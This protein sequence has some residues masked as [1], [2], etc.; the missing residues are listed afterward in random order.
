MSRYEQEQ[1][2][3][4]LPTVAL[5]PL[6]KALVDAL[7]AEQDK[8]FDVAT[9]VH[10]YLNHVDPKT[11]RKERLN[12]MKA[13][14]RKGGS[15]SSVAD[16]IRG[17]MNTLNGDHNQRRA[18][19]SDAPSWGEELR[20][21]V[22][23][24]LLPYPKQGEPLKLATPLKK[25]LEKLPA[26]TLR[27]SDDDC[28]VH[29][30]PKTRRVFWYVGEN[31]HAVERA[32]ESVLGQAFFRAL[33]KVK[34]TRATGGVFRQ[35]DEYSRD[36]SMESGDNPVFISRSFGPEGEKIQEAE[37]GFRSRRPRRRSPGRR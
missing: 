11:N 20:D 28:E 4:I 35:S 24:M 25:N 17:A 16:V 26:T 12:A 14:I 33:D 22:V 36:A 27:F 6:R 15:Y 1:G 2:T 7:N 3:L 10:E 29:I 31:N 8:M 18:W 9:K 21:S 30:D 37:S 32:H 13:L 5:A 23:G 19:Y 34:W